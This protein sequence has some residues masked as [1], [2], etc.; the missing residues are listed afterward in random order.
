M[1]SLYEIDKSILECIDQET[2]ELIDFERFESLQMERSQKIE[3]VALWVKNLQSDA[4]AYKAE[5]EAFAEREKAA[6]KKAEQLKEWLAK[7]LEGQKFSTGKCAVSFRK[8]TKLEVL[9]EFSI[10]DDLMVK[11]VTVK[12]DVYAIKTL[13]KD[14]MVVPGCRL[15]EN[16]NTQI[17]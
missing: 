11:T 16:L 14:G 8:S 13:M 6:T 3:N 5:K 12:P 7:V 10:P 4:L 1:A 2:G 9:D 15:V 17:K